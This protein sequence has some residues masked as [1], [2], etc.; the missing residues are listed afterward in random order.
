M[1]FHL[2]ETN[3]S[4]ELLPEISEV[5]TLGNVNE[6]VDFDQTPPVL[7]VEEAEERTTSSS[8]SSSDY[9][10]SSATSSDDEEHSS[11]D[12]DAC[13]L[14]EI[15]ELAEKENLSS[16]EEA[17]GIV[18][19]MVV[20]QNAYDDEVEFEEIDEVE[21]KKK[22]ITRYDSVVLELNLTLSPV[23][24][25]DSDDNGS[26]RQIEESERDSSAAVVNAEQEVEDTSD[27][28]G[29]SSQEMRN[30][31]PVHV[32]IRDAE[33][34]GTSDVYDT[35]RHV[36]EEAVLL[37]STQAT[38]EEVD[39]AKET[40]VGDG[41]NSITEQADENIV[42]QYVDFED[43]DKNLDISSTGVAITDIALLSPEADMRDDTVK[44]NALESSSSSDSSSSDDEETPIKETF[45]LPS[46]VIVTANEVDAPVN[47]NVM[48]GS[49]ESVGTGDFSDTEHQETNEEVVQTDKGDDRSISKLTDENIVKQHVDSE[50]I[51]RISLLS[52]AADVPDDIVR[53]NVQESSSSSDDSSSDDEARKEKE[54]SQLSP[55]VAEAVNAVDR[56]VEYMEDLSTIPEEGVTTS[57]EIAGTS[58]LAGDVKGTS[59]SKKTHI[60]PIVVTSPTGVE[61]TTVVEEKKSGTPSSSI[62]VAITGV[63]EVPIIEEKKSAISASSSVKKTSANDKAGEILFRLALDARLL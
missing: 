42:E 63:E 39:H 45:Q 27:S 11:S 19:E 17:G 47:R 38:S 2:L 48:Y 36:L 7:S 14:K 1:F 35:E 61:E 25:G 13:A 26:V 20:A 24:D 34:V 60:V 46:Q 9:A 59:F 52:P 3:S 8:E 12:S 40:D 57:S 10:S 6:A 56:A 51:T 43:K 30:A 28:D 55:E 32:A 22:V 16:S 31:D 33:S 23:E 21:E 41:H 54:T 29:E 18:N 58:F 4:S 37:A 49:D 15:D 53:N 62:A 44:S 5:I 50:P